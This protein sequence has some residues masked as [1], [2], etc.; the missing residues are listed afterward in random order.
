MNFV[1]GEV[2][3]VPSR[4]QKPMSQLCLFKKKIILFQK[5]YGTIEKK[6]IYIYT[7]FFI[8]LYIVNQSHKRSG[9]SCQDPLGSSD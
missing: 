6:Y 8:Y 9:Q 7:I 5:I 3:G 2:E 4:E 1:N